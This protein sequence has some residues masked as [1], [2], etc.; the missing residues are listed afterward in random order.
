MLN[1]KS[2]DWRMITTGVPQGSVLGPLLFL[3][4][5]NDLA[6]NLTTD[7]RLFADDTSL[8]HVLTDADISADVLNHDLKAIE[9]WAFQWKMS[10]DPNSTKQ[11][12]QVIFL[13]SLSKLYI[14]QFISTTQQLSQFCIIST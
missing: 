11:T 9:T 13:P 10:F 4:Y 5:I 3:V 7:V 8:F 1:G 14:P 6:G 2:S 12:E